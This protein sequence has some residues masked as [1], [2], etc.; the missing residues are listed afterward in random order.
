M[1]RFYQIR[2]E[3]EYEENEAVNID[4]TWEW[5]TLSEAKKALQNDKGAHELYTN[6]CFIVEVTPLLLIKKNFKLEKVT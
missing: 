2:C 3:D 6:D 5:P 1:K 4:G